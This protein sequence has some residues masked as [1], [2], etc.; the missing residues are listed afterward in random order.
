MATQTLALS[1][2]LALADGLPSSASDAPTRSA[3]AA[4]SGSLETA[5]DT[6]RALEAAGTVGFRGLDTEAW[7]LD[8]AREIARR[9]RAETSTLLVLGIG[10]SALGAS[11]LDGALG[12]TCE[13]EHRLVVLDTVDPFAVRR[14]LLALDPAETAV[15]VISKSGGTV[16][17]A[18]LFRTVLPWL[19]DGAG[20]AWTRRLV[21]ITDTTHGALRPLADAHGLDALPVPDDVGGRFSV[22]TAVGILPAAYRGLDVD[23]LLAGAHS[24]ADR[25]RTRSIDTNPAW[26]FA[27][28]HDLWWPRATVSILLT[29]SERLTLMGAWYMQLWAESLGKPM[30]EGRAYGWTPGGARGPA[31]QHSQLQL[32]QEGPADRIVTVVRVEEHGAD[33]TI[34]TLSGPEDGVGSYLAGT[35][36]AS[37]LEAERRGTTAALVSVGRP[38][39]ELVVPRVD[40]HAIGELIM[41]FESATAIAGLL[42]GIN[43]F[44]QPGVEAGKQYAYGLLGREGFEERIAE[45]ERLLGSP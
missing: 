4:L 21:L 34:P 27:G 3:L 33:L 13:D 14:T 26:A 32:W 30:E 36:L 41:L 7:E 10:G 40:A 43:P 12:P 23:A 18:A 15:A 6:L 9:L 1:T 8:R 25:V 42:R 28:V 31:D 45:V 19:R 20:D 24:M 39:L 35:S 11:A 37:L 5:E 29:Y 22:L 17:T 38:V 16:E 44:D 2:T